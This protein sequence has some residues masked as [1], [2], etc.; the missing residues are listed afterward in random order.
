MLK[1]QLCVTYGLYLPTF[2]MA[3]IGNH[4]LTWLHHIMLTKQSFS[5]DCRLCLQDTCLTLGGDLCAL[6]RNQH[7]LKSSPFIIELKM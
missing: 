3:T 4:G 1:L 5:I 2:Q 6:E 7:I